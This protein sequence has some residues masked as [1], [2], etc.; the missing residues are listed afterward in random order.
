[1]IA[2]RKLFFYMK[3]YLSMGLTVST[4][5]PNI[6][7][8][9]N[10]FILYQRTRFNLSSPVATTL[11]TFCWFHFLC[12]T[13]ACSLSCK[14]IKTIFQLW[15]FH[16]KALVYFNRESGVLANLGVLKCNIRNTNNIH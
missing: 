16:I 15:K 7:F 1:M 2:F 10:L 6:K 3:G 8:S 14:Q 4:A 12:C 9:S 13:A 11:L 5:T